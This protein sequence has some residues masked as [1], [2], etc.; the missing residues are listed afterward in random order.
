[1]VVKTLIFIGTVL[2]SEIVKSDYLE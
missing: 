2:C 1:V